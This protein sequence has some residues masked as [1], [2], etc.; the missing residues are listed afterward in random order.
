M[1]DDTTLARWLLTRHAR[2]RA[3]EMGVAIDD[4]TA[5]A[6]DPATEYP[7]RTGPDTRRVRVRHPLAVVVDVANNAI[8][9]VMWDQRD[10]R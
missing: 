5:V 1:T 3:A 8:I 10:S 7:G 4:V 6:D 9:T 2:D